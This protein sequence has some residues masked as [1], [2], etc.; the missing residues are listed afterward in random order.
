MKYPD[1]SEEKLKT[2]LK[3]AKEDFKRLDMSSTRNL[4]HK[5]GGSPSVNRPMKGLM[6]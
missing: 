6:L 1:L 5:A 3:D 4:H 2:L